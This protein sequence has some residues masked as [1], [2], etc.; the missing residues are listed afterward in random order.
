MGSF[1][2][3]D[4]KFETHLEFHLRAFQFAAML[5]RNHSDWSSTI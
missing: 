1:L 4:A 3:I 5:R 2:Q